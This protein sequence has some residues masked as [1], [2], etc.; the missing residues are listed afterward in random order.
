MLAFKATVLTF[1]GG[2]ILCPVMVF[3]SINANGENYT[4]LN[5]KPLII[6]STEEQI[7]S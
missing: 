4:R 6:L 1:C 3:L 7:T 2:I 5:H